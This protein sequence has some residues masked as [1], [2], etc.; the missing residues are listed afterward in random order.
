MLELG[1]RIQSQ[2]ES[3]VGKSQRDYYLREQLKAIQK[4]LGQT[5]ERTQ[6]IDELREKI[7]AAGMTDEAKKEALRELDRL[8]K[9]PP[10]AA[11]YTVAR[12]YLEWLVALPW[13]KET[14]DTLDLTAARAV[15]DEDHWGLEKVKDRILEYLAV[16]TH[17]PASAGIRSSASW[18]RRASARPRSGARS[19][20]RSGGSSTASRSAACGT[21]PRSAA[22]GGRI[23]ARC[24]AR[25]SRGCAAPS[26]RTPC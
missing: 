17:P 26:P 7:E 11:E 8:S 23:S 9:M 4:E 20:G 19:R 12:T 1:S 14:E 13:N 18:A 6:E 5:D 16:K 21:R 2:V 24:R 3:E 22:I 25:S 10:A 15:L